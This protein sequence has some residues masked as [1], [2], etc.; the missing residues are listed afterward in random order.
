MDEPARTLRALTER[1]GADT[2]LDRV[3]AP[4]SGLAGAL[5]RR[6]DV[7]SLLSGGWL[8]HRLHPLLTDIP[9]GAWTSASLLDLVGGRAGRRVARRLV[10]IG[11]LAA[12]PTA[13]SGLSDW[14]DTHDDDRRVGVVHAAA[15]TTALLLQLASWRAR[16]RGHRVRGAMLSGLGMGALTVGGYLGGHLVFSR[17]VGVD[18]EVPVVDLRTYR[19]VGR[20]EEFV[21]GQPQRVE[22]DGT[23]LVVVRRGDTAHVL[24]A[25]CSHAG[26]PLDEGHVEGSV[27]RCPWHGS[28]FSLVDG[29]V[30]RGPATAP[31]P[32][33]GTRVRDGFLEVRGPIATEP[34]ERIRPDLASSG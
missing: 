15:N 34:V 3:A 26:G 1:V 8:G 31:Q 14:H 28:E 17:R 22:V 5:T 33:Y 2:R 21:D 20:L 10:G 24:A 7:K 30:Q 11:V 23:P 4:L 9:I 32:C 13:L 25:V 18:A 6:D 29:S 16:G 19:T 27:V 12:A